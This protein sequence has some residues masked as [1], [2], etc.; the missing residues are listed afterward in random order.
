MIW[1]VAVRVLEVHWGGC[2]EA[3]SAFLVVFW[4]VRRQLGFECFIVRETLS[5]YTGSHL[6]LIGEGRIFGVFVRVVRSP[7]VSM[8]IL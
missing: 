1:R 4:S 6:E 8:R 7:C 3:S 5:C 2:R